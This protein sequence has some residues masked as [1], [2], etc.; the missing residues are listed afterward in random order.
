[1][2]PVLI[3]SIDYTSRDFEAI[4]AD[5]IRSINFYTPDWTDHNQSDQGIVFVS[6]MAGILDVLHFYVD[7]TAGEMFLGTAVKRESVVKLL[8]LINFELRSIVPSS[9]DVT[10]S[11]DQIL[12]SD[13][14]LILQGTVVQT[15]ASESQTPVIFETAADLTILAG[16]VS[17]TISAIEGV[18]GTED[19][20]VSTGQAFQEFPVTQ[21]IIVEDSFSL[22]IDE[23]SGPVLWTQVNSFVDSTTTDEHYRIER[24]ANEAITVFLGDNLQG[25]I[26]SATAT[27]T[28]GFRSITGDRGGT[29]VFGNVGANTV[30]ILSTTIFVGGRSVA[31]S[32]NN[33]AQASGG[34][35]RQSIEEAKRLGPASLLALGRAV[36]AADYVTLVEQ[37]GGIAKAKVIQGTSN[38]PCCAC[39]LDVYV[40][41]TGGGVLSSV[42]KQTL[43]DFLDT[44]KMVGTCIEI[45]DPTYV[46]VAITGQV[47]I[48]SNFDQPTVE[49]AV[50][51]AV[52]A[53]FNLED[54]NI[55][56]G[57]DLFLGNLF[58]ILENVAGVDH[59]DLS[60]VS[61]VPVPVFSIAT[62][63]AT[64]STPVPGQGSQDETWT[65]TFLSPTTFSVQGS[66]SG[67]QLD[68]V[69][70]TPYTSDEEEV[71]F[72]ITAGG[73]PMAVGDVATFI[74]SPILG[75][76]PMNPTE[77]A[78]QGATALTSVVLTA[79]IAGTGCA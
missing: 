75:N 40:A 39:N 61:R 48:L 11:L 21:L 76:V 7:R 78:Q 59:V 69:V 79:S 50:T 22:T 56:F 20:G 73:T 47:F 26:P 4:R 72:T 62:G 38:D 37:Q 36:T 58:A 9:V 74:T 77:I 24:D 67:L 10:F 71:A 52:V 30:T 55:D 63:D 27:L 28:A 1:M 18:T 31:L 53:F 3:P 60:K 34:E 13:D 51:A 6:L 68:G 25:K 54:T 14:V 57:R 49:D 45:K 43:L 46:D 32:V 65:V 23:G 33:T 5:M 66:V 64:F 41:P 35:D 2:P 44:V 29:G 19:L 12:P 70:G 15:V 17:G 16:G 42:A 8:K